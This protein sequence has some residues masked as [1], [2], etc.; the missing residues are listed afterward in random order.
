[1]TIQLLTV[2]EV[3]EALK[4]DEQFVRAELRRKNLRGT[5]LPNRAG[6]RVSMDDLRTYVDAKANVTAVRKT[7][8]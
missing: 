3:A 1:M 4:C 8:A 5:K 2:P 6:W 7:V